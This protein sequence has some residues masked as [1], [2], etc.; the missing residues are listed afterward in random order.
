MIK[1]TLKIE[2]TERTEDGYVFTSMELIEFPP[3]E[4]GGERGIE[5]LK[6]LVE[7]FDKSEI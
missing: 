3:Q 1:K 4:V 5:Y 7:L 6:R 2:V